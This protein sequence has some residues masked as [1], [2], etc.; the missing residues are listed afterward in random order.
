MPKPADYVSAHVQEVS[1]GDGDS[2]RNNTEHFLSTFD[3]DKVNSDHL[4]DVSSLLAKWKDIFAMNDLDLGHTKV[5]D[6]QINLVD[7]IP[8][9]D[10]Y[11]RIPPHLYQEVKDHLQGLLDC[12][13]TRTSQ[14]PLASP[15]VVG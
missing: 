13:V 5:V 4:S 14:S 7:D 6:H 10:K 9:K 8:F 11:R 15:V 2:C 3:L 1:P 12:G